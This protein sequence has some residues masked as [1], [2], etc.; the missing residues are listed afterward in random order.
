MIRAILSHQNVQALHKNLQL[1]S[2]PVFARCFPNGFCALQSYFNLDSLN[3]FCAQPFPVHILSYDVNWSRSR[4]VMASAWWSQ[5]V[6]RMSAD[7]EELEV[8]LKPLK[9]V[10]KVNELQM[11]CGEEKSSR[12]EFAIMATLILRGGNRIT[13][14]QFVSVFLV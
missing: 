1:R 4:L 12:K 6:Y 3:W 11:V 14:E 7:I 2:C 10:I 8:L 5:R 9:I 13:C